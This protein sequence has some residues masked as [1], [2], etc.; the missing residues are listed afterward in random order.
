MVELSVIR[1]LV[2]IAGVF[3]GLTYY[4]LNIRNQRENRKAQ[5]FMQLYQ[6]KFD[7]QGLENWFNLLNMEW[8]DFDDF[9]HKYNRQSNPEIYALIESQISFYEGL[10]VLM[11]EKKIDP[12]MVYKLV[13]RRILILWAKMRDMI[14]GWRLM[15]HGPGPDYAE[16]FEYLVGEMI[17]IRKLKGLPLYEGRLDPSEMPHTS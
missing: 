10:G 2:A 12:D 8:E 9:N 5:L 13:G 11:Q 16:P 3:I 4:I 6:R 17:K 15:D 14:K 1:D 7:Q